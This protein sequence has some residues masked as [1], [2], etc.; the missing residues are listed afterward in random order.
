MP[1]KSAAT[2]PSLPPGEGVEITAPETPTSGTTTN[3]QTAMVA[4]TSVEATLVAD[5][6]TSVATPTEPPP[7]C[8]ETRSGK[9]RKLPPSFVPH[10]VARPIG[11]G[12]FA[13]AAT[14]AATTAAATTVGT[15]EAL[16]IATILSPS[17][18]KE[19]ANQP[20]AK[21]STPILVLQSLNEPELKPN[22][23]GMAIRSN[24]NADETATPTA[25]A[26]EA[27][28]IPKRKDLST[29]PEQ[30]ESEHK[31]LSVC[32][33]IEVAANVDTPLS[34]AIAVS[35]ELRTVEDKGLSSSSAL[36]SKT[37]ANCGIAVPAVQGVD[38]GV[39]GGNA[40]DLCTTPVS[41]T[42]SSQSAQ[43]ST[44]AP[45]IANM[46]APTE[47][48]PTK[49]E[50]RASVTTTTLPP[51]G[52][53]SRSFPDATLTNS[54]FVRLHELVE[55]GRAFR[56]PNSI[57]SW[58]IEQLQ[59]GIATKFT[60]IVPSVLGEASKV[61]A[62]YMQG[63]Y[64]WFT[65][66]AEDKID[67]FQA[68][69]K[70]RLKKG[71]SDRLSDEQEQC[72]NAFRKSMQDIG[73]LSLKWLYDRAP[74]EDTH[75]VALRGLRFN[76]LQKLQ[77]C[78]KTLPLEVGSE[79]LSFSLDALQALNFVNQQ[80][81]PS[82]PL[83]M[84]L[85]KYGHV[86]VVG[87]GY[88]LCCIAVGFQIARMYAV[89]GFPNHEQEVWLRGSNVRVAYLSHCAME[90]R[91][92]L[93]ALR[94][95]SLLPIAEDHALAVVTT[96]SQASGRLYVCIVTSGNLADQVSRC[97]QESS[98]IINLE[99]KRQP[100]SEMAPGCA[101]SSLSTSTEVHANGQNLNEV[102]KQVPSGPRAGMCKFFTV[103]RRAVSV[104]QELAEQNA[105]VKRCLF[106]QG[107]V[108]LGSACSRLGSN[109]ETARLLSGA[110]S[111]MAG[112]PNFTMECS[113]VHEKHGGCQ[114]VL[115]RRL[116][117]MHVF[118]DLLNWL[119]TE[120]RSRCHE[121]VKT[122]KHP[123]RALREEIMQCKLLEFAPCQ[124]HPYSACKRPKVVSD[125]TA[126]V[127]NKAQDRRPTGSDVS[128][129]LVWMAMHI[130]DETPIL[131]HM[132]DPAFNYE[133][134]V[135]ELEP[136]GR[137]F[138][139][140]DH[141]SSEDVGWYGVERTCRVDVA[142]LTSKVH[143][144]AD[145]KSSASHIVR[146]LQKV[147]LAIADVFYL[148]STDDDDVMQE[149][150]VRKSNSPSICKDY[151]DL[152]DW[153]FALTVAEKGELTRHTET[154]KEAHGKDAAK[155]DTAV[156]DLTKHPSEF[157]AMTC[158]KQHGPAI[159][160]GCQNKQSR[161]W[162]PSR[163]RWLTERE[164]AASCAFPIEKEFAE[165]ANVPVYDLHQICLADCGLGK[166]R[167]AGCLLVVQAAVYSSVALREDEASLDKSGRGGRGGRGV[168][169]GRGR[170][171][172]GGSRADDD[173]PNS[174]KEMKCKFVVRIIDLGIDEHF[175]F[176]EWRTR[177][178]ARNAAL[179]RWETMN[180]A[181]VELNALSV[182]ALKS[183][184]ELSGKPKIGNKTTLVAR[185]I[186]ES[187]PPRPK[188][189]ELLGEA[190]TREVFTGTDVTALYMRMPPGEG[191]NRPD[192]SAT[193]LWLAAPI[194]LTIAEH[195]D[196]SI[197]PRY[198][199]LL[200]ASQVINK[201]SHCC[202]TALYM[203]RE[204]DR[205]EQN[206]PEPTEHLQS[207]MARHKDLRVCG[208]ARGGIGEIRQTDLSLQDK[209][210]HQVENSFGLI[211]RGADDPLVFKL[212]EGNICEKVDVHVVR[213]GQHSK[214]RIISEDY[215]E[216]DP[217]R[218]IVEVMDNLTELHPLGNDDHGY[219]S[220]RR[221]KVSRHMVT[222]VRR[223]DC[224]ACPI[225]N[226]PQL[227]VDGTP[228]ERVC[229]FIKEMLTR[230]D[231]GEV[232]TTS[233]IKRLA[234]R[235]VSGV[236][237]DFFEAHFKVIGGK[238]SLLDNEDRLCAEPC[239]RLPSGVIPFMKLLDLMRQYPEVAELIQRLQSEQGV[240]DAT[241]SAEVRA[242]FRSKGLLE[243]PIE[244]DA[245]EPV[246]QTPIAKDAVKRRR[247]ELLESKEER[248]RAKI[249]RRIEEI[250]AH[251][252]PN[253]HIRVAHPKKAR[254]VESLRN[255][256]VFTETD[257]PRIPLGNVV[258]N[259]RCSSNASSDLVDA[260]NA[261]GNPIGASANNVEQAGCSDGPMVSV[262]CDDVN[263]IFSDKPG[264][265][266]AEGN[267]ETFRK[268]GKQSTTVVIYNKLQVLDYVKQLPK[269]A[270][271]QKLAA[272]QFPQF[273][274]S[275]GQV[276]HWRRAEV[277]QAWR[278]L[279]EKDQRRHVETPK[280][281][282]LALQLPMKG[283]LQEAVIP[284]ALQVE[285]DK[286]LCSR[287]G[288]A[289]TPKEIRDV[290]K[291]RNVQKSWKSLVV[292]Y[293]ARIESA[294]QDADLHNKQIA[295]KHQD[296][297]YNADPSETL[298]ELERDW[299]VPTER[300]IDI[301][302][303][304]PWVYCWLKRWH[305]VSRRYTA[306]GNYLSQRSPQM[307]AWL[308]AFH[309]K[310]EAQQV[311]VDLILCLDHIWRLPYRGHQKQL[312][313]KPERVG[314]TR[315]T[316]SPGQTKALHATR[317]R[318]RDA[319]MIVPFDKMD[320]TKEQRK[321]YRDCVKDHE[322]CRRLIDTER[323]GYTSILS[324]WANGDD[325]PMI[326]IVQEN[327]FSATEIAEINEAG[328][329]TH[330]FEVKPDVIIISNGI[331]CV[332]LSKIVFKLS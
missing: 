190:A 252:R 21:L 137:K 79:L 284:F 154:W 10:V 164:V 57:P 106:W 274:T 258:A 189:P 167:Y 221:N 248:K 23:E 243:S 176:K 297:E 25:V 86:E 31:A 14:S 35:A 310:R 282:R 315:S 88:A 158:F 303:S 149:E 202:V 314:C 53:N 56:F 96:M 67:A 74:W 130:E 90:T 325:G 48:S 160:I 138:L 80:K 129:L 119:P 175:T 69:C 117:P 155:D 286:L 97:V 71:P 302:I 161:L 26:A 329:F 42:S 260:E 65:F 246:I 131:I 37:T 73:R 99:A 45:T 124:A 198:F 104:I 60:N 162:S 222:P 230:A 309:A 12:S 156:F 266:D 172:T 139:H 256:A 320:E 29:I 70:A 267:V 187:L 200:G 305:W 77:Q 93:D 105:E 242:Y 178:A 259:I 55:R 61:L 83:A 185:L 1:R 114:K 147:P 108:K 186:H 316:L 247:E 82:N 157:G 50:V 38:V 132:A 268:K 193:W 181:I 301:N 159:N 239:V 27:I 9:K 194:L 49:A 249:V 92:C 212:G 273:V 78:V 317:T 145:I 101:A 262:Q 3:E 44:P 173:L 285:F 20:R 40:H 275:D 28:E 232:S 91:T 63:D 206:L 148:K 321:Q 18:D 217:T 289:S 153:S 107:G 32:A 144:L 127:N 54:P 4:T 319:G 169:R 215:H 272:I 332:K 294:M 143:E 146:A 225:D 59:I 201:T 5:A 6:G 197:P 19:T 216:R 89:D 188:A 276:S 191:P 224:R 8:T 41:S 13:S 279:P 85:M 293:N 292:Q 269:G 16:A 95:A 290:L 263:P 251:T 331:H 209:F 84:H 218:K 125:E 30:P 229:A 121:I 328:L 103:G 81:P 152:D 204:A 231:E 288:G 261:V 136:T 205:G 47:F 165:I 281:M 207:I 220:T 308:K 228:T 244:N 196:D 111:M 295:L 100:S 75:G 323:Y 142:L 68:C 219:C 112:G 254:L 87:G 213:R 115:A 255:S 298:Q 109:F 235:G 98:T 271:L 203:G 299:Q 210:Q 327:R 43:M 277:Q 278:E 34:D 250:L 168:G 241:L 2:T 116:R 177:E 64:M 183:M 171:C 174:I 237:L 120:T 324:W 195:T 326:V 15:T 33:A 318:V 238:I 133:M 311:D 300:P 283:R 313:K 17:E 306:P 51:N 141:I 253:A 280:W 140:F 118:G 184:C 180:E 52:Q 46:V 102:F 227:P 134:L 94:T 113:Y 163:C 126:T 128:V 24:S 257:Q 151:L 307:Q 22:L 265:Q 296:G 234:R 110:C 312:W 170:G 211:A 72:M 322:V 245:Q 226:S 135:A 192:T 214:M 240:N 236:T 223:K 66:A 182:A 199:L 330:T 122:Q 7:P 11:E 58:E 287:I 36:S 179:L 76:N 264:E 166:E 123:Y 304:M 291:P 208:W 62:W 270:N 150:L 233:M 39:S